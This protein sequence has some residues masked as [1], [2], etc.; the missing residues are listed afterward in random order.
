MI[1]HLPLRALSPMNPFSPPPFTTPQAPPKY[2]HYLDK[3]DK[4]FQPQPR[5][6]AK[7]M[8]EVVCKLES[9]AFGWRK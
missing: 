9:E 4:D 3:N 7:N 8:N 6:P 5:F 2:G 1:P